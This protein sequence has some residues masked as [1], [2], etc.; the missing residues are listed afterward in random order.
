MTEMDDNKLLKDF[1]SE[2]KQEI[3]DNGFS[4]RV[5]KNLPNRALRISNTWTTCCCAIALILF[6]T[7]GGLQA[8]GSLL[9]E[10]IV[11]MVSYGA[12]NLDLKSLLIAGFVL[13]FLGVR[14]IVATD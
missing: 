8:I 11:L 3:A 14:R 6:F 9:N 13:F 2:H 5:I 1:F 12:T 10:I 7:L 4:R